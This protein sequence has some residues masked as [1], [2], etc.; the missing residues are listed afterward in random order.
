MPRVLQTTVFNLHTADE[1][2]DQ[3][4]DETAMSHQPLVIKGTYHNAILLSEMDWLAIQDTLYLL[5][6][7]G[8]RESIQVGLQTPVADCSKELEW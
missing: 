5:S 1:P 3:L 8:M 7:P 6:I 4:I 2:L